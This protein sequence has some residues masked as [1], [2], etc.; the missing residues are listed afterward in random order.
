MGNLFTFH[1]WFNVYAGSLMPI[2]QKA[3][4]FLVVAFFIFTIAAVSLKKRVIPNIYRKL[5]SRVINFFMANSIIGLFLWMF[6]FQ[7]IPF[8][9]A[10]FWFLVWIISDVVWVYYIGRHAKQI[11]EIRKKYEQELEFKRYIP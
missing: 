1:Y 7:G 4:L 10:R 9:S 2:Y 11:P 8:F 6:T 3:F 5:W